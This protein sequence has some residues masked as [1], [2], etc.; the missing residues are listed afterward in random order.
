MKGIPLPP[1]EPGSPDWLKVMSAS[2]VAAML[3]LSPWQSRFSLWQLMAGNIDPEPDNDEFRRGHYL[4][5][6][7]AQ[8]FQDQHPN[9]NLKKSPSFAHPE[10]PW[11]TASPDRLICHSG[12]RK[13]HALLEIKTANNEWEW[14]QEG[15]DEIPPGYLAQVLWQLDT[16]GLNTAYV[17][18]LSPYMEFR[19]YKVCA[20]EAD[21]AY[22]R[23]ECVKFMASLEAGKPPPV[24]DHD[25][26]YQ[27]VR[28]LS[29][30]LTD[31]IVDLDV[32]V[33]S[34][35]IQALTEYKR[36]E[37]AKTGATA[38]VATAMGNAKV[39]KFGTQT[40]ARRQ[41][42]KQADGT[43]GTP[44]VVAARGLIDRERVS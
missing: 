34:E 15:T 40:Y 22:M 23:D 5:P 43:P 16:T 33:A 35:Y 19:Q 42:K 28:Q 36:A 14:G 8:W 29:P 11:Q 6:A 37:Q 30:G 38:R 10:R 41:T 24:D 20:N 4:E 39:A 17:A 13:P 21:A 3:G 32:D 27:A 2:K 7:I 31:D 44:Y 26:T 12:K 18:V 9:I 25:A 1:M